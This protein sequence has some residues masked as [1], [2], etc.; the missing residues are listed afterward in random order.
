MRIGYQV[1][2]DKA[3]IQS[4]IGSRSDNADMFVHKKVLFHKN[5]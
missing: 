1:T 3:R 4:W 5:I 2:A